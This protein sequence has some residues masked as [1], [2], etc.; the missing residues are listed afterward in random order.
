[1]RRAFIETLVQVAQADERVVFVTADLG[2]MAIE[3]FRDAFPNRFFNAGVA[4]QNMIGVCTGLAESGFIPFAYSI[5]PFALLRPYEF[6]RNGPVMH[7][8]P[9]RI[10]GVGGGM[11]YGTNG[12]THYGLEDVGVSRIQPGLNVICPADHEQTRA[13]LHATWDLPGPTYYRL[14]KDDKTVVAGLDGR[15]TTGRVE[16]IGSGEDLL[17]VA[18]GNAAIDAV[19][20]GNRLAA[21]GIGCTVAVVASV[22][23]APVDD[24]VHL[25]SKF[26]LALTVEAHYTTGGVGSMVCEVVAA[27]G[28]PC[29][30]VRC[31]VQKR[32]DGLTGSQASLH[33]HY[34][35]SPDQLEITALNELSLALDAAK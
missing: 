20:A 32:P 23:P 13:A 28:I 35:F 25:T 31:G 29:R 30:V 3:P 7:G 24:L 34:G 18:M 8:L 33:K 11:E 4:E 10:V 6:I 12:A 22:S 5:V 17:I 15:F 1:V 26:R 9:V 19:A 21:R 16:T 14:G 27:N 2:Y